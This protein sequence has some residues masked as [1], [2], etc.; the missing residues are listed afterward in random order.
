MDPIANM[1]VMLKNAG[2]VKKPSVLVPYSNV[3]LAILNV[4]VKEGFILSATK[5]GKKV[6]KYIQCDLAYF[7]DGRSK[8][9]NIKRMS[10]PSRR[11]YVKVDEIKPVRQGLGLSVLSTPQGVM[12]GVEA[13]KL[14]VGGELLFTLW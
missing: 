2:A 1:L 5:K 7:G 4:L 13:K 12:T 3:K 10:K 8:I 11:V 14:R 6:K 9:T